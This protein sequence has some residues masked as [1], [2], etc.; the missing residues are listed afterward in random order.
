MTELL[1]AAQMRAIEAA[2]IASG[3]VTGLDLME[4]AGRG[5]VEAIFEEWPELA[6]AAASMARIWAAVR[7][8]VM[9][10]PPCFQFA[11]NTRVMP[12]I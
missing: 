5:V 10:M 12:D 11:R 3:E 9:V 2:A 1:S 4:R 6:I 7:S 8:S